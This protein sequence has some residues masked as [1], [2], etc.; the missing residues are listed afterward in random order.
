MNYKEGSTRFAWVLA[1]MLAASSTSATELSY[2]YIGMEFLSI[3]SEIDGKSTAL[4]GSKEL[5]EH[6]YLNAEY[7]KSIFDPEGIAPKTEILI[8][9]IGFG[10]HLSLGRDI[11]VFG[12]LLYVKA[13]AE[14]ASVESDD[15]AVGAE[16]GLRHSISDL[17][18]LSVGSAHLSFSDSDESETT[19]TVGI[20]F[21][22]QEG[23]SIGLIYESGEEN[24]DSIGI[25]FRSDF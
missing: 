25:S 12:H 23:A 21:F 9:S 4:F 17:I 10:G 8:P 16:I 1:L 18:E 11:D 22:S 6:F 19:T 24:T 14:T 13:D 3:N 15:D 7:K 20:R 2:D 5:G